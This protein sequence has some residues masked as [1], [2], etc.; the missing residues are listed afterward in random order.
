MTNFSIRPVRADDRSQWD[1]LYQGYAD[2][3]KVTQTPEMRETVW[4]W[5]LDETKESRG[6]LAVS[7]DGKVLGLTHFRPFARPLSAT[8]GCFLDDLFVSSD[9]RGLGVADALI[10][11]VR[12]VAAENGW[13]VV[14]WITAENNYRGRNVYD[15]MAS[16]TNWVTYDIKL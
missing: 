5:L 11:A 3:Y 8:T 14:R 12:G 2:F 6:L 15:R 9:A 1:T 7:P 16:K 10:E 13:S 4:S